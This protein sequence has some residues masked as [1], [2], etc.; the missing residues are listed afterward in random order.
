MKVCVT[1]AD[2]RFCFTGI[3]KG[4]YE[5]RASKEGGFEI[6]H[7]KVIVDPKNPQSTNKEINVSIEPGS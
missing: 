1:E 5:L 4:R 6:T 7:L 3:P 2:G